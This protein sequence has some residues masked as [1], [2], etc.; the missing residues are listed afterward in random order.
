[1]RQEVTSRF[2]EAVTP[3]LASIEN[4]AI[5]GGGSREPELVI[6]QGQAGVRFHFFGIES[7]AAM[8]SFEYLDLNTAKLTV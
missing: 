7:D 4:V 1:M 8:S 6:L 2:N 5:V 3:L